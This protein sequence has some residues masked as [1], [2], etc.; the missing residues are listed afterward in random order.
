MNLKKEDY[1]KI[2]KKRY[3]G[4][5]GKKAIGKQIMIN[6]INNFYNA[7]NSYK[8]HKNNYNVGDRVLLKKGILLH[9]T[10]KN[11]E[12]L[13]EIVKNGLVSSWFIDAR[14]SK[15]PSSVGVWNLKQDYYLDEYINFYSGGTVKYYNQQDDKSETKVIK[16]N[17]L[18]NFID[19]FKNKDYLVWK[20][21]QTKEAR[22][23]PSLVQNKVQIGII[24]NSDNEEI[25]PLLENDILSLDMSDENVKDFVL[26]RYYQQFIKDRQHK[27]DFFTDRESAI[28]FGIPSCFIEGILVGRDYEKDETMLN[29]IKELLPNCYICNLDGKVIKI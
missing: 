24:F 16:Y 29:K 2:T 26:D 11:I 20:M 28:L 21:E 13:E 6:Q 25:K 10:Y 5:F 27:D 15:Y 12:G 1:I 4:K 7:L 8:Y 17:E 18:S 3:K 14:Q 19:D 22:F 9:G 23:L